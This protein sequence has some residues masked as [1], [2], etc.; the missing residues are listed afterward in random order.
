MALPV[1]LLTAANILHADWMR[2][3]IPRTLAR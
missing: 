3:Q 1:D 2:L